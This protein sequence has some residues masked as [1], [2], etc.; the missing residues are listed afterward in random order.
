M[1]ILYNKSFKNK[2]ISVIGYTKDEAKE[3][4]K[5][6]KIK[7]KEII[8][9][10]PEFEKGDRFKMNIIS[11]A[12]FASFVLNM[13]A[14]PNIEDLTNWYREGMMNAP[15]IWFCKMQGKKK[16]SEK[17][18]ESNRKTASFRAAD[19]NEYSWNMELCLY[20]NDKGYEARFT[21]CGIC[22]LLKEYGLFEYTS[23]MCKL[24]YA[25]SEASGA[26]NF[27]RKCTIANGDEYCDCGYYKMG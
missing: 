11:C 27:V 6:A 25:M 5:K 10:L 17:D 15:T 16:F 3:I 8:N 21:K 4:K 7:Y 23:A 2:L 1:W 14:K 26:S 20:E 24:D 13:N 19:R 22:H 12:M 18:I 9:K